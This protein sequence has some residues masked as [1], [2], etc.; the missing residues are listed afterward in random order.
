[1]KKR[2]SILLIIAIMLSLFILPDTS[3][4][5]NAAE[6]REV[7][8]ATV[9]RPS[10]ID[11]CK[12][13]DEGLLFRRYADNGEY[14]YT[15]TI[16]ERGWVIFDSQNG[17]NWVETFG[18]FLDLYSN[19]SLSAKID[20]ITSIEL[21]SGNQD[22]RG[23]DR[24]LYYL[25]PGTYYLGDRDEGRVDEPIF[26]FFLPNSK[27]I[28][29]SLTK[30][31]D[32]S[33][34]TDKVSFTAHMGTTKFVEYAVA[35]KD[36]K[37]E[38][39]WKHS[40]TYDTNKYKISKNGEYTVMASFADAEWKDYPA[41]YSFSVYDI[42]KP[43]KA[44]KSPAPKVATNGKKAI[45]ITWNKVSGIKN[46]EL[47]YSTSK[48]F[49]KPVT[50]TYKSTLKSAKI[51]KLKSKKKYYVR[52]RCYKVFGGKKIYSNWS[53]TKTITTK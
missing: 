31:A 1:M 35:P 25:E 28:S 43:P 39:I 14:I 17:N 19:R 40:V 52:M 24:W 32:G 45:K 48:N 21:A 10:E 8:L 18:V 36:I 12:N 44:P 42:V 16:N 15:F 9:S 2:I 34:Y 20:Y 30:A 27:A 37:D 5:S 26:G 38:S 46:Y 41:M 47:Q 50:K 11:K 6:A 51:N 22:S 29:H 3:V 13:A 33:Y 53:K 23:S 49:K 4:V 7:E